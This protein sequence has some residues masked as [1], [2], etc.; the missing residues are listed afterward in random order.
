MEF[1]ERNKN[2]KRR[3]SLNDKG[4][5]VKS[6]DSKNLIDFTLLGRGERV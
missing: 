4:K 2:F 3:L 6:D 1:V 5:S